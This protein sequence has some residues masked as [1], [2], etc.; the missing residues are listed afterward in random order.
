MA[1]TRA[2]NR[3]IITVYV[4]LAPY[5]R[6]TEGTYPGTAWAVVG[7][8]RISTLCSRCFP[9]PPKSVDGCRGSS[10]NHT[11]TRSVLGGRGAGPGY[12]R[13]GTNLVEEHT[14]VPQ[15]RPLHVQRTTSFIQRSPNT[16]YHTFPS[17]PAG[18]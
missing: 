16:Q 9:S 1:S 13:A 7:T 2:S 3:S 17:S 12:G 15:P 6:A 11:P 14:W 18:E 5:L 10:H 8:G 4:S